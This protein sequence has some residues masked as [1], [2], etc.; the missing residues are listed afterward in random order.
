MLAYPVASKLILFI[1]IGKTACGE[2]GKNGADYNLIQ[3]ID[4][5]TTYNIHCPL[6]ATLLITKILNTI[7]AHFIHK[8]CNLNL[9]L[10]RYK[11]M[12]YIMRYTY[13]FYINK[14]VYL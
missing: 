7:H 6:G 4:V 3:K 12:F 14:I 1:D 9:A 2:D 10:A 11:N 5:S 13:Y 8:V